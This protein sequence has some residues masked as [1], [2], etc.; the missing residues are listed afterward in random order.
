MSVGSFIGS[1]AAVGK[2]AVL[3]TGLHAR[4][5]AGSTYTDAVAAYHAK[6]AELAARREEIRAGQ[7]A[8]VKA[9]PKLVRKG[10]VATA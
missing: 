10:R 9:A 7:L 2:H 3:A 1:S 5:F 6:D 4:N 8:A